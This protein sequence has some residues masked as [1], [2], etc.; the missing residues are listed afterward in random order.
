MQAKRRYLLL[1]IACVAFLCLC[2]FGSFFPSLLTRH[3]SARSCLQS[4]DIAQL[5]DVADLTS[6]VT[7]PHGSSVG[8]DPEP[9][10][11]QAMAAGAMPTVQ[12]RHCTM[13][14]CFNMS[15]C[16]GRPFR[17]YVYPE[18]ADSG[19]IS[20][21][22]RRLLQVLTESRLYT[23]DPRRACVFVLAVDTLDRDQ[24]SARFVQALPARLATMSLWNNGVNHVI[25]NLFSGTWPDYSEDFGVDT[26]YAIL[27][28]ASM[29]AEH[30]RERFDISF[31]LMSA[32]HAERG[33]M[34]SHVTSFPIPLSKQYLIG[35]KGK[36]YVVGIGSQT[37]NS[38]Y[39]LH[40]GRS[41]VTVTTCRHGNDWQRWKDER[42]D[43][44]M[45]QYDKFDYNAL[46]MNSTFC[47]V[48]R[49]RRVGSFR[50]LEVLRAGCIP[51]LLSNGWRLPFDEVIDWSEA[52]VFADERLTLQVPNT[53]RSISNQRLLM[54][55]QHA[56]TLWTAY[57]S[58]L[59][60]VVMTTMKIIEDRVYSDRPTPR[61]AWMNPPGALLHMRNYG[62]GSLCGIPLFQH[63]ATRRRCLRSNFTAMI[64]CR[65]SSLQHLSNLLY[66]IGKSKFVSR[67]LLLWPRSTSTP[68]LSQMRQIRSSLSVPVYLFNTDTSQRFTI[69]KLVVTDAVLM[70]NDDSPL[71]SEETDFIYQVW[72]EFPERIVGIR[73]RSHLWDEKTSRWLYSEKLLNQYSMVASSGA[74]YHN[75]YHHVYTE[76]SSP[77]ILRTVQQ[78]FHCQEIL[79]NFIVSHASQRP[80]I[81]VTQRRVWRQRHVFNFS[82]LDNND[83]GM[84]QS[85]HICL[86]TLAALFGYMP[87][88]YS[89]VRMDPLLYRDSVAAWRKL[90][91]RLET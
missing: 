7:T 58:S 28:K 80:P 43:D 41:V 22:Y 15:R 35:F 66:E 17:V 31:P 30:F 78:D 37:R 67:V 74:M 86:N 46:L 48:P 42:C 82:G 52:V 1:T 21:L 39:H 8:V 49:G 44:D 91:P 32:N 34:E 38:L 68:S 27:A 18:S 69:N 64:V 14:T 24:L 70:V 29:T 56:R 89:S 88:Q 9:H 79:L 13:Q 3:Q 54:M 62:D 16:V 73:S 40:N 6:D 26:G 10:P 4:L 84:R 51:V 2:Y 5:P 87:L 85:R 81:K 90:Y 83:D 33:V 47:L 71:I 50:F 53:V 72:R 45:R 55:R 65:N 25:F 12:P 59:E 19:A 75:Y 76:W 77:A 20:A 63:P 36:R 23:D 60:R 11:Q 61:A 57:F